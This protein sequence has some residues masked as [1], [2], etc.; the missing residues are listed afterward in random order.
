M[1]AVFQRRRRDG[2]RAERS[3]VSRERRD[4]RRAV[5]DGQLRRARAP[6]R[7]VDLGHRDERVRPRPRYVDS[8]PAQRVLS[9]GIGPA[10]AGQGADLV[11]APA[12][13]RRGGRHVPE[14]ARTD[15]GRQLRG[16]EFGGGA[17][18]RP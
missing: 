10:H 14:Q 9:R 18:A 4:Q 13:R 5:G 2:Q 15:A 3:P 11:S 1:D 17:V 12:G 7:A 6:P 8:E 16:A